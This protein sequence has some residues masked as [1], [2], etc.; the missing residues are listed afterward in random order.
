MS[1]QSY[2]SEY[3]QLPGSNEFRLYTATAD[4]VGLALTWGYKLQNISAGISF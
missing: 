4:N 3:L 2:Y 1:A